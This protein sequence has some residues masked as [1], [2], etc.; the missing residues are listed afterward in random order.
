MNTISVRVS[1]VLSRL[2]AVLSRLDDDEIEGQLVQLEERAA[3]L[4]PEGRPAEPEGM[5]AP[6]PVTPPARPTRQPS[7][8]SAALVRS[9]PE[10]D[11]Y[12]LALYSAC[13]LSGAKRS[14]D[15]RAMLSAL[16]SDAVQQSI[17]EL[18]D[19]RAHDLARRERAQAELAQRDLEAEQRAESGAQQ[20]QRWADFLETHREEIEALHSEAEPEELPPSA[21]CWL[22]C[23]RAGGGVHVSGV[24]ATIDEARRAYVAERLNA[25]AT[26]E[27]AASAFGEPPAEL[28]ALALLPSCYVKLSGPEDA[29]RTLAR[30]L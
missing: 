3:L 27:D 17:S 11:L 9:I 7:F 19:Q 21:G 29:V 26:P 20:R 13:A 16:P 25:I 15:L 14:G 12:R 22:A 5:Q 30:V 4:D 28:S 6:S 23:L 24:G 10:A 8:D 18:A 1:S 2:A